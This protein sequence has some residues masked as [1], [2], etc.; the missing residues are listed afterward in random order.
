MSQI[1]MHAA[2]VAVAFDF[3]YTSYIF[4]SWGTDPFSTGEFTAGVHG[5]QQLFV[6][7]AGINYLV[8]RILYNKYPHFAGWNQSITIQF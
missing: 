2:L 8:K 1:N 6:M 5:G 3:E 4:H 7:H